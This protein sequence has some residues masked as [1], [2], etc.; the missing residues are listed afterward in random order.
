MSSSDHVPLL[1][2]VL[3][4]RKLASYE[5]E[6]HHISLAAEL[7][8]VSEQAIKEIQ[9]LEEIIL[10]A[11]PSLGLLKADLEALEILAKAV[12]DKGVEQSGLTSINA[13]PDLNPR[14]DA[15]AARARAIE[16]EVT[17]E[18]RDLQW[19]QVLSLYQHAQ[20]LMEHC[21]H[22]GAT[23]EWDGIGMVGVRLQ[24]AVTSS[25][26]PNDHQAVVLEILAFITQGS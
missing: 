12:V 19:F 18:T 4:Q 23:L 7:R 5:N 15:N 26:L 10:P 17:Q 25:F 2:A 13:P 6:R 14:H 3:F 11:A 16:I 20:S 24:R 1:P 8:L 22:I 9:H 21:F